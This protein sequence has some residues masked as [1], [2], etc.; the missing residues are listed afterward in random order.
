MATLSSPVARLLT[1]MAGRP[2]TSLTSCVRHFKS[3]KPIRANPAQSGEIDGRSDM[4]QWVRPNNFQKVVLIIGKAFKTRAEIPEEISPL[5]MKK[6]FDIFRG[7]VMVGMVL[8]AFVGSYVMILSGRRLR[9]SGDS[10]ALRGSI[11]EEQWRQQGMAEKKE[12]K[13]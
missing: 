11:Q 9:D 13:E 6:A 2:S 7:R 12:G 10:L 8:F 4:R 5:T 3:S 1:R